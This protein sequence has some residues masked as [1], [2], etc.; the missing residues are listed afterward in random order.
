MRK[1]IAPAISERFKKGFTLVELLIVISIMGILTTILL[2]N[3]LGTRERARDAKAKGNLAQMRNALR[4]FYNDFQYYPESSEGGA[5]LGCGTV[6]DPGGD[7]CTTTFA[8]TGTGAVT[9][10][11]ELP[12]S[13][14]YT[15]TNSGDG[16]TL[17]TVLE[18]LSD[19]DIAAS[20]TR[21][22]IGSPVAG[23][24]YVCE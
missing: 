23:A 15:Q 10:M 18:N 21:C 6:A 24:Y 3:L 7:D 14:E 13:F 5:L 19:A 20:A 1:T 4:L 9:Y 8:T 12:E 22:G 2:P 11:R 16:Y 17:Y